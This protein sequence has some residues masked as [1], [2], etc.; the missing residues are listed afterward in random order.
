MLR[1]GRLPRVLGSIRILPE[2]PASAMTIITRVSFSIAYTA[3]GGNRQPPYADRYDTVYSSMPSACST[4]LLTTLDERRGLPHDIHAPRKATYFARHN[5]EYQAFPA[6]C[7]MGIGHLYDPR[8]DSI[9]K[10][11]ILHKA[12]YTT[13]LV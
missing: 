13:A 8:V 7:T 11:E 10:T 4:R 2:T 3:S 5:A 6:H 9:I 12:L 1:I